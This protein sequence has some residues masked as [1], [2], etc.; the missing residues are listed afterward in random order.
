MELGLQG[1]VA[2]VTG[3]S[4]GMGKASAA[5]LAADRGATRCM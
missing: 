4:K 2:I 3:A 5:A 1:T